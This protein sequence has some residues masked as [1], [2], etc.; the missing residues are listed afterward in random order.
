MGIHL[1]FADLYDRIFLDDVSVN[2]VFSDLFL[3][4][5]SGKIFR[6]DDEVIRKRIDSCACL[7]ICQSIKILKADGI[8]PGETIIQE[9]C[10]VG[11]GPDPV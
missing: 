7:S 2:S 8:F 9:R 1:W 10:P 11:T 5:H 3:L 6:C 4:F